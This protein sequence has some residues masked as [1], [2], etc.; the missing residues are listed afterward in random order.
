ME[1][2]GSPFPEPLE[3]AAR[4]AAAWLDG[5]DRQPVGARADAATLRA[6]LDVPLPARGVPARQV[7]DELARDVAG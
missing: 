5:L 6:R 7:V 4:H 2:S 3:A 1:R